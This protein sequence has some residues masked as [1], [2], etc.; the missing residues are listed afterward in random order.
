MKKP[1]RGQRSTRR[2]GDLFLTMAARSVVLL[3]RVWNEGMEI[4]G[5]MDALLLDVSAGGSLH[6]KHTLSAQH[7]SNIDLAMSEMH[8]E[9]SI[10]GLGPND[11]EK[12]T[13]DLQRLMK[14]R[15]IILLRNRSHLAL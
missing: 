1:P 6:W 2:W 3:S 11:D 12:R 13:I 8:Y 4:L 14:K 9:S 15:P 5:A 10:F 7:A